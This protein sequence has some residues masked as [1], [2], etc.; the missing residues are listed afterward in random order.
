MI[1]T[2]ALKSQEVASTWT[3][4]TGKANHL[5]RLFG[6]ALGF[7]TF[8]M[9]GLALC[10]VVFPLIILFSKDETQSRDMVRSVIRYVFRAFLSML[11]AFGVIKVN[12]HMLESIRS[13]QGCLVICNHPTL[14]DV[15]IIMAHLR[16]IQCVV[17]KELWSSIILGGVVRAAGYIRN[18]TDP[19]IFLE[20]CRAQLAAG[21]NIIIFPEGTRSRPGEPLTLHRGVGNLAL[22]AE[23]DIQTLILDCNPVMLTKGSKWHQIPPKR[24]EFNLR[25]GKFIPISNYLSEDPRSIRVRALMRDI[26]NYYNRHLGYE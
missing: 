17:K 25:V 7:A 13:K 23:A 10:L 22:A 21:E 15:V 3:I 2:R 19:E 6:T 24:A 16:N 4:L 1:R 5:K 18:D 8:G 9:G 12:I 26:S 14:I 11:E 20:Q